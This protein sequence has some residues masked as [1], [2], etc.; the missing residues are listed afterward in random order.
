M[1]DG[2]RKTLEQEISGFRAEAQRA[3]RTITELERERG[4]T[5][6]ELQSATQQYVSALEDV[7]VRDA[8]VADLQRSIQE[9]E[10]RLRQQQAL[11]EAVRSDRN[12]YSK[13]LLEAQ[14]EVAELRR[15]FK[16]AAHQI[17][18]LREEIGAKDVGLVKEHFDHMKAR[19]RALWAPPPPPPPSLSLRAPC[20][21]SHKPS[22]RV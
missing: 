11:Y 9:G 6:L 8:T 1:A 5:A 3:E 18:Q 16:V 22:R 13:N 21:L 2:T 12:L 20:P 10:A 17:E 14:A 19:G 4:R 15:R 7:K